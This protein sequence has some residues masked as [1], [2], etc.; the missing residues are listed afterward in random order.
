MYKIKRYF[1]GVWKQGK[2]VRWPKKKELGAAVAVVLVVVCFAAICMMVDDF[3]ISN[4]LTSLDKSFP[5]VTPSAPGTTPDG[6]TSE[7][8][9]AALFRCV[10]FLKLK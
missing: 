6:E 8:V 2:K 4:I 3:L 9:V 5:A 1:Q 7:E 10:N